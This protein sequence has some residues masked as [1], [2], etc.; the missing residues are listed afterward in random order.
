LLQGKPLKR[1][2][3][4]FAK[5]LAPGFSRVRM[6]GVGCGA[7]S[8]RRLSSLSGTALNGEMKE[9]VKTVSSFQGP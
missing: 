9:T 6:R 7:F 8:V 1:L 5:I 4:G 3:E 2:E